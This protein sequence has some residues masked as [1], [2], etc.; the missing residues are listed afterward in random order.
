VAR[1]DR[2]ARGSSSCSLSWAASSRLWKTSC[3]LNRT[4]RKCNPETSPPRNRGSSLPL[5]ENKRKH[6][7]EDSI[8]A[9]AFKAENSMHSHDT[10][11]RHVRRPDDL[12]IRNLPD[13]DLQA[14]IDALQ[15]DLIE[16][17][18]EF[19]SGGDVGGSIPFVAEQLR[20]GRAEMEW[21]R[22]HNLAPAWTDGQLDEYRKYWAEVKRRVSV[23][24][25]C[26]RFFPLQPLRRNGNSYRC[27]CF[28]CGATNAST[29]SVSLDG[30]RW[31]CFRCDRGGDVFQ[32]GRFVYRTEWFT[33][34]VEHLTRDFGISRPETIPPDE[35]PYRAGG[36]VSGRR[37]PAKPRFADYDGGQ[38]VVR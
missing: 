22:T 38:V 23:L 6:A 34:V 2:L 5:A 4:G 35:I 15:R 32:L 7:P 30:Q 21:R 29:F 14:F 20:N 10:T 12:L 24:D 18:E 3:P 26:A 13:L 16:S 1:A 27:A 37:K 28:I 9:R 36:I 33:E 8:P 17:Q 19:D 11:N 31:K 25:L